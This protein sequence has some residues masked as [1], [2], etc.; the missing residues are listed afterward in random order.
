MYDAGLND[1]ILYNYVIYSRKYVFLGKKNYHFS[2]IWNSSLRNPYV[3][4][5]NNHFTI[6]ERCNPHCAKVHSHAIAFAMLVMLPKSL[7]QVWFNWQRQWYFYKTILYSMTLWKNSSKQLFSLKT[8]FHLLLWSTSE[9]WVVIAWRFTKIKMK[10][11]QKH[12]DTFYW[13]FT[14]MRFN[15][16]VGGSLWFNK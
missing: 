4:S 8:P 13:Y 16:K 6:L 7:C 9:E 15:L 2:E 3:D 11:H 10:S 1:P 5:K 12:S 14:F